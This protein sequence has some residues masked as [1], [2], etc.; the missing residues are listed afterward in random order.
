MIAK[1]SKHILGV[2]AAIAAIVLI[3]RKRADKKTVP[4]PEPKPAAGTTTAPTV[5]YK[6]LTPTEVEVYAKDTYNTLSNFILMPSMK[7]AQINK[8]LKLQ[9]ESLIAVYDKFWSRYG[10]LSKGD[11]ITWYENEW[12]LSGTEA[13]TNII[14]T[15]KAIVPVRKGT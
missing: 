4:F 10:Y 15:L 1:Y 5:V 9:K 6:S 7:I 2:I 13:Q 12:D 14:K 8:L 3:L 11:L